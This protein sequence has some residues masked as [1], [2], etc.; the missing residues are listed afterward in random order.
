MDNNN[1]VN[2]NDIVEMKVFHHDEFGDLRVMI[3]AD[4]GICFSA[5]DVCRAL[6]VTDPAEAQA[7]LDQLEG[8]QKMTLEMTGS[9]L[10]QSGSHGDQRGDQRSI[11]SQYDSDSGKHITNE[12]R[13]LN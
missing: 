11:S 7:L 13:L 6:G 9:D 5:E 4:G 12:T 10:E 1:K 2:I 3:L 8:D